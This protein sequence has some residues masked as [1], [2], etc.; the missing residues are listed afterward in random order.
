[1]LVSSVSCVEFAFMSRADVSSLRWL[2]DG[3]AIVGGGVNVIVAES[4]SKISSKTS[5][6]FLFLGSVGGV[7]VTTFSE[8]NAW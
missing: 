7:K 8:F 5:I 4:V 3:K 2:L 1:M 6:G